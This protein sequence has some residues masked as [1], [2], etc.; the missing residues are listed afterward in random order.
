MLITRKFGHKPLLMAA[1]THNLKLNNTCNFNDCLISTLLNT[2]FAGKAKTLP[3]VHISKS[4]KEVDTDPAQFDNG[5]GELTRGNFALL[6]EALPDAGHRYA[7]ISRNNRPVMFA[8]YQLFTLTPAN[9]NLDTNNAFTRGLIKFFVGVKRTKILML[10]NALENEKQCYGYDAAMLNKDEA[11]EA[12]AALAEKIATEEC[13]S[14]I[15]LKEL[16]E[17]SGGTKKMLIENGYS[18]PFE[19]RIM[20]MQVN[21]SWHTLGDYIAD[22]TRKYK[23]R[24][25]KIIAALDGL[26]VKALNTEEIKQHEEDIHRLFSATIHQQAFT[27]THPAKGFFTGLRQ[28]HGD[29]FEVTGYFKGDKLVGFYSAFIEE[30][31][32]NIYYIGFD[33]QEN[34]AHQLYFNILF[35]GLERAIQLRKPMLEL[36]RTSFD[37]KASLGAKDRQLTY[38]LKMEYIPGFITNRF[39]NYFA[40]MENSRWKQR[41]PLKTGAVTT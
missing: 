9:F 12:A 10:G 13:A 37:A 40:S 28:L 39:V 21:A 34:E 22:L 11:T 17:L 2:L 26:T 23:T 6:E 25:N 8:Y 5:R 24:A 41:N 31:A 30:H 33:Y 35:A 29:N 7:V 18:M 38:A 14:A 27:L 1:I 32:Y 3:V 36:G 16:P 20:E 19:D 15:I 4:I